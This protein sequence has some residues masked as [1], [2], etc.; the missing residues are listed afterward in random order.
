MSTGNDILDVAIVGGGVSGLYCG[1]RI[2]N[3][4][5]GK[6]VKLFE[7][8]GR[9]GGRLLSVTP[10][11]LPNTRCELGGMRY[12][13]T[14]PLIRSLVENK[15]Q[16]ETYPFPVSRPENLAYLR[17]CR[18]QRAE[19]EDP[20]NIPY[21]LT[22]QERSAENFK[23][24]FVYTLNKVIPGLKDKKTTEERRELLK[25]ASV[26]GVS[27]ADLGFW[28]LIVQGLS[29]EGYRFTLESSGY[30][31]IGLNWNAVDT[32]LLNLDDLSPGIAYKS[33][34]GGYELVPAKLCEEFEHAGGKVLLNQRLASFDSAALPGG[35]KGVRLKFEPQAG[36]D[37][38]LEIMAR[39]LI[40]AMP[41]RSLELLEQSGPIFAPPS[42]ELRKNI[43]KWI[44]SVTPIPLFKMFLAFETEWWKTL[45]ITQGQSVTDL[46]IRQCYYWPKQGADLKSEPGVML[47]TYN[48][49]LN[50]N[51]WEGYRESQPGKWVTDFLESE[52]R[53]PS[54]F[55]HAESAKQPKWPG[56]RQLKSRS[57]GNWND[58]PCPK[59]LIA[60][61]VRELS[62]L[63]DFAVPQPY[64]AA[65]KDWSDDPFGGGVNFWNIHERSWEVIPHMI[66]PNQ[67]V[68]VYICGEAY[69]DT[70]GWVEGALRTAEKVLQE[71]LKIPK[72]DWL[73]TD[74]KYGH[75]LEPLELAPA[76][77]VY[78]GSY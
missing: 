51:F 29:N 70:Q 3:A 56:H 24:L 53:G 72:P 73:T 13:T 62:L 32:I 33:L 47:A 58:Y 11:K 6:R 10:P 40:L 31:T 44:R 78:G 38:P 14:Q 26:D 16:F 49:T 9:V 42:E 36:S 41:R 63:H 64:A 30:D 25:T 68:P 37:K 35:E 2:V 46:P 74:S 12:T 27:V 5:P 4:W 21:K 65:F 60:E 69:S 55:L 20:R 22:P 17:G 50:I 52:H 23:N 48:D 1:W 34:V 59:P 8:S 7:M 67:E 43:Q 76:Q 18:M 15:F 39:H 28:N 61:M 75:S 77:G 71:Q 19:L 66:R 45:G 57:L 54:F